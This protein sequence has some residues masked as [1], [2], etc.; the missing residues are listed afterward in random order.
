MAAKRLTTAKGQLDEASDS[1]KEAK[2]LL[3]EANDR[4]NI[5]N[6]RLNAF[7]DPNQGNVTSA[8]IAEFSELLSG[9]QKNYDAAIARVRQC[10]TMLVK[11]LSN[12][13]NILAAENRG[14]FLVSQQKN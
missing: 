10:A 13:G 12:Y 5:A 6:E 3:N 9:A 4:L 14:T 7:M 11:A 1:H 8:D 2:S